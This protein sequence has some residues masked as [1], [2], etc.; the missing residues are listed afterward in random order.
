MRKIL[1]LTAASVMALMI[2]TA[3][4]DEA[5]GPVEK[6]D[7]TSNRIWVGGKIFSM[8]PANTVGV[9]ITDLKEGDMVS[10]HFS[11]KGTSETSFNA[12]SVTT[13]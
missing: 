7:L 5:S 13:K 3:S 10:V 6:I 2:G 1:G 9:K 8:A 12:L 4:A 11:S